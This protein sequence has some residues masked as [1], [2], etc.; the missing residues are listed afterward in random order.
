M[1]D[2]RGRPPDGPCQRLDNAVRAVE[3][4]GPYEKGDL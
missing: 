3:D 2:R 1:K 4:A